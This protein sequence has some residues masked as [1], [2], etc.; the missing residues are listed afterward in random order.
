MSIVKGDKARANRL[1]RKRISNRQRSRELR[2]HLEASR[3]TAPAAA[4]GREATGSEAR[5]P[6]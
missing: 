5:N 3:Q 1:R 6:E 4:G 2:A